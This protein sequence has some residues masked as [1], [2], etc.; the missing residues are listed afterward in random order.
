MR[1]ADII[2]RADIAMDRARSGRVAR[3]VWFDAGMERALLAQSEIEQ[4]IRYGLDH[5]QFLPFFEPQI[6]LAT[7]EIVG[8][9]MLARWNHPLSGIISPEVFIPVAEEIGVIGRLSEQVITEA[10]QQAAS[11]D[12]ATKISVNISPAQLADGWLAQRIV[13][14]LAETGFPAERLVI[15]ITESSLFADIDLA[16]TIVTSLKNQG[17]R[18]ALDDFGTGFS[19]LAHLPLAAVRHHQDRPELC[20]QSSRE[21]RERCHHPCRDNARRRVVGAGVRRGHRGRGHFQCCG[22]AWH[23]TVFVPAIRDALEQDKSYTS[24]RDTIRKEWK[25]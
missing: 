3:P 8:F 4:G 9:Q 16:R 10:L 22:R 21:A 23:D 6:D 25:P 19:S 12:A 13:R 20:Q 5:G 15:E 14:I 24:I 18:L 7:G 17:I 11:W 1:I 2:R